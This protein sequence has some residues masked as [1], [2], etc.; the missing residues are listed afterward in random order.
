ME[1]LPKVLGLE[2]LY[3]QITNLAGQDAFGSTVTSAA[4]Y[5]PRS[6]QIPAEGP[7]T[8]SPQQAVTI[9]MEHSF[10]GAALSRKPCLGRR[11]APPEYRGAGA[12]QPVPQQPRDARAV[13]SDEGHP[14]FIS[15]EG[16]SPSLSCCALPPPC[17]DCPPTSSPEPKH[18]YCGAHKPL[19]SPCPH[20]P[21]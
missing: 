9:S 4:V 3:L 1:G 15:P 6:W 17:S 18:L 19:H 2:N 13:C 12:L 11:E 8:P 16:T 10:K 7:H 14:L 21:P 5:L 20:I